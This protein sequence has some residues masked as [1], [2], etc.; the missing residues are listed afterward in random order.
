MNKLRLSLKKASLPSVLIL[1]LANLVPIYGIVLFQ[2]QVFPILFLF[3]LENVIIGV[4]N[5]FKMLMVAQSNGGTWAK[6][7]GAILFFCFHYG[8]FTLVHG[9][10]VFVIFGF[11]AP[12]GGV[13]DGAVVTRSF[14]DYHIEWAILGL[15]LSHGI[16][17]LF[18]YVRN[19]E[20]E[21]YTLDQLMGQPYER[22]VLLHMTI[23]GGGFLLS[24]WHSPAVGLFVLLFIKIFMDVRSHLRQHPKL[25]KG[26]QESPEVTAN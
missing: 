24:I 14:F 15:L 8:M 23:I 16:S 20:Y 25:S 11:G 2:W 6:K 18:N 5:V 22:V 10:F 12:F 7:T 4:F 21:Q 3:W 17:F 1:I 26:I 13:P 9:V 19:R